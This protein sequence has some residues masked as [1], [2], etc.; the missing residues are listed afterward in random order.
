LD[1][2]GPEDRGHGSQYGVGVPLRRASSVM[3]AGVLELQTPVSDTLRLD[4]SAWAV[5]LAYSGVQK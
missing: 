4:V 1:G 2:V 3:T 5:Q